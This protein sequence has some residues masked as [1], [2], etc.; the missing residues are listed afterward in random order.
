MP[1]ARS[2]AELRGQWGAECDRAEA[3]DRSAPAARRASARARDEGA[4]APRLLRA[5][6]PRGATSPARRSVREGGTDGPPRGA[7]PREQPVDQELER[8]LELRPRDRLREAPAVRLSPKGGAGGVTAARELPRVQVAPAEAVDVERGESLSVARRA[9]RAPCRGPPPARARWPIGP[10]QKRHGQGREKRALGP[11]RH[12]R[13]R[14]RRARLAAA[15][16]QKRLDAA[17]SRAGIVDRAARPC[18]HSLEVAA[19]EPPQA[20]G[21]EAL[22]PDGRARPPRRSPSPAITDSQLAAAPSGAAAARRARGAPCRG[23]W[24]ARRSPR[25]ARRTPRR[26]PARGRARARARQQVLPGT[27]VA[28]S[29][30]VRIH[31]SRHER[32]RCITREPS[33]TRSRETGTLLLRRSLGGLALL[34][35]RSRLLLPRAR[36]PSRRS[37]RTPAARRDAEPPRHALEGASMAR[38]GHPAATSRASPGSS[39]TCPRPSPAPPAFRTAGSPT[40]FRSSSSPTGRRRHRPGHPRHFV[41]FNPSSVLQCHER[42]RSGDWATS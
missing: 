42:N 2:E 28:S 33:K 18:Q 7:R 35:A 6:R 31:A 4:R 9:A 20:A 22:R 17:P 38:S 15:N 32:V 13:R 10:L 11:G 26:R 24:R 19:V 16:A 40:W 41:F 25:P 23:A 27:A 37:P 14:P 3:R 12:D 30:W 1:V 29:K 8:S 21:F 36:A 34:I 39:T 5:S